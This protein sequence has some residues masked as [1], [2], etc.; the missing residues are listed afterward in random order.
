MTHASAADLPGLPLEPAA[1]PA[2]ACA[3]PGQAG[4]VPGRHSRIVSIALLPVYSAV[5]CT[6]L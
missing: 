2:S 4:K 3:R 1:G 6:L 5:T